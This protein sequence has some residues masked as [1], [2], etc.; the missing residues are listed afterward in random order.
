MRTVERKARTYLLD[1]DT[2]AAWYTAVVQC[3]HR[4]SD[5]SPHTERRGSTRFFLVVAI[6]ENDTR[7]SLDFDDNISGNE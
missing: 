4:S 1:G 7:V 2:K 3:L 6:P 5:G